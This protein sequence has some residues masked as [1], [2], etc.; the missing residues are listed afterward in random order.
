MSQQIVD[1]VAHVGDVHLAIV[2][3]ITLDTHG[4]E[5]HRTRSAQITAIGGYGCDG[6][7]AHAVCCYQ[8]VTVNGGDTSGRTV[9]VS[10][11]VEPSFKP[12]VV[13]FNCMDS[14]CTCKTVTSQ[15]ALK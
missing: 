12:A 5:S 2:V 13:T 1:Q 3:H 6:G 9:A 10:C 8:A 11:R 4:Q 14:A 15:E 7:G